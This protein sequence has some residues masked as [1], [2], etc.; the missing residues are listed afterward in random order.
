MHYTRAGSL[1]THAASCHLQCPSREHNMHWNHATHMMSSKLI[2]LPGIVSSYAVVEIVL[3]V[4]I[5]LY[6]RFHPLHMPKPFEFLSLI[7]VS[8]TLD[9]LPVLH[10]TSNSLSRNKIIDYAFSNGK[11]LQNNSSLLIFTHTI[12]TQRLRNNS[13]TTFFK[14]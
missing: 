11:A 14:P 5:V 1:V 3:D 12:Q 4:S 9:M 10:T 2:H 6:I 13:K 7:L 8:S